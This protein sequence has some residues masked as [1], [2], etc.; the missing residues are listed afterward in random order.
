M[1]TI[2]ILTFL[3]LFL[4]FS[5]KSK[6]DKIIKDVNPEF[7]AYISA[8]TSGLVSTQSSIQILLQ[9]D[10]PLEVNEDQSL[11]D[12]ILDFSPSISGKTYLKNSTTLEFIP[13]EK[14]KQGEIYTGELKLNK[15]VPKVPK[16]LETFEFQFQAKKQNFSAQIE[17][18]QDTEAG[19][20]N[21][22]LV[23]NFNT[24]DVAENIDFE[25][26]LQAELDGKKLNVNWN[27]S[28]NQKNH[29][30]TIEGIKADS[31]PKNLKLN[32]NGKSIEVDKKETT[33]FE[34]PA[35]NDFK[36]TQIRS[37]SFPEQY[38]SVNFSEALQ[39]DLYLNGLVEI[40]GQN[41]DYDYYYSYD[42]EPQSLIQSMVVNGNELKIYTSKKIGGE[43][44]LVIYPGI[45]SAYGNKIEQKSTHKVDLVKLHP[46]VKFIGNGNI[47]PSQ[48]GKINLPFE[49]VGLRAVRVNIT[50]IFENNIHQFFQYNQL[51]SYDNLRPVGQKVFSKVISISDSDNFNIN[52][53]NVYQL[54]LSKFIKPEPGAIYNV[55]FSIEQKFASYPCDAQESNSNLTEIEVV[56][57]DFEAESELY[58]YDYYYPEN[59]NWQDRDNPCTPSY[60]TSE[61]NVRKNILASNLG[62]IYKSGKDKKGYAAVTDINTTKP[63]ENVKLKA[64]DLQN[65]LVGEGS[66]D[67]N[68]FSNFELK[69]KPFLIVAERDSQKGYVRVDNGSSLSLSNFDVEGE[70]S[71]SGLGGFIYGE[72]GVWRPGDKIYLTFL[73]DQSITQITDDQPAVLE[74]KSPDGQLYQRKVNTSPTN[75]FYTFELETP[76]D[77]KTGNWTAQVKV[78]GKTFSKS[79]KIETIKPNRLKI[80]TI[81][82]SE[83]LT[84]SNQ[85]FRIH[86]NWLSGA[87]AQNLKATVDATLF[88]SKTEFKSFPKYT[89]TDPSRSFFLQEMTVFDGNLNAT[90][91][92]QIHTNFNLDTAPPGKLT[93]GLFTKVFETGGDFSSSYVS[94]EFSPYNTYVGIQIPTENEYW[95]MLETNKE[96][97]INVATVDYKGSGISK[98]YVKVYIYRL[99]NSWWYNS[100]QNDLAYYVNRQYEFLK[101]EKVISTTNGKGSFKIKIPNDE[102]GNYFIRV[103]DPESGHAAGKTI[104]FD[105]PDWRSRGDSNAESAAILQFK[106][107]KP[108]YKVGETAQITI[109]SSQEG[110][111]LVSF[112]NGTKVIERKWIETQNGQTKFD[113]KIT[114]EMAP[115]VYVNISLIQ[116]HQ[117]TVNDLPIRMYGV[118]PV[119]VDNPDRQLHPLVKVPQ[120]IRPNS[121]YAVTV[122]EKTGKPMTYTLAVVDEGLLDLTNFKTPDVY[123]YFNQKQALGVNTWDIYNYVLGAYGGRIESV[124]TIGGDQALV[125]SN[126]EKINRFKPIVKFLGPFILDKGK[127]KTHEIHMENYIGS[128]K[129]MVVAANGS[130]FGSADQTIAVKQPLMTL[131]TV[132]RVLNP[133]DEIEVPINVFAMENHVK[134]VNVSIQTD[135]NLTL[136]SPNSQ[137]LS[138]TKMGDQ[139][140][141]FKI[142]VPQKL[143]K[144]RILVSATSGKE[145]HVD[146]IHLEIRSPNPPMTFV[147]SQE[148]KANQNWTQNFEPFGMSGTTETKL[149]LS[150]VPN[151]NLE[152]RLKYLIQYPHGCVE[153]SVSS[154][155]PQLYLSDLMELSDKQKKEIQY[156]IDQLLLKLKSYQVP[157]GG[158]TYWPGH[159]TPD[160]W[161]STY[162]LHFILKA[163]SKGY[164][165]P[166]GLK[167]GLITYQSKTAKQWSGYNEKYYYNDLDQAYRLYTLALAGKADLGLMNRLKEKKTNMATLW[168]L[169]AT[170]QL[171]GQENTAKNLVS[172]LATSVQ[173][174]K[175]EQTTFG[176]SLRDDAMILETLSLLGDRTK[177]MNV[178]KKIAQNLKS[179]Q[180]YSTQTTAY[181]LLAISEFLGKGN[182]NTGIQAEVLI[183][184]KSQKINS[185]KTFV[186]IDLPE[187]K[188]NFVVKNLK[189]NLLFVD[190]SRTGV[191]MEE[192][193][194]SKNQNL[195]MKV[196]YLDMK[197]NP[198]DP[199]KLEQGKDF[200]CVIILTNPGL[201]GN[202]QNLAL[203]QMFPSGWEI[204]NTRI[205]NQNT[206]IK[207]AGVS[208]Q[209]FRDDRV[210][211]YFDLNAGRQISITVLLNATYKGNY[212][213][214]ATYCEAMYDNSISAVQAG[215]RVNVL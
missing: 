2:P 161:G 140:V 46:E 5:C 115:N 25:K 4:L 42:E 159:G 34:I 174:Y 197:N 71:D 62:I 56:S 84:T 150:T 29:R 89:F 162:A 8:Y 196:S 45:Q 205:N 144:T 126:K 119:L 31:N 19:Q 95:E 193:I 157:G 164:K 204:I 139:I 102:Y 12:N 142:K 53:M 180:W 121:K 127:S 36:I 7:A 41:D 96:H 213:M 183:N 83:I 69:K 106:T 112:E 67:S 124:F 178:L 131:T 39:S 181:S 99:K 63:L 145:K 86:A 166:A 182:S 3:T 109:P 143:G 116:P 137:S 170:Y 110:R 73:M 152:K 76:A 165:I 146:T 33:T 85:N 175:F 72:R 87:S 151:L 123:N 17:G 9:S 43:H 206:S 57:D 21:Y 98:D 61:R 202:Y 203:T 172:K 184:G 101:E 37:V 90:G 135:Q 189:S 133:G 130:S 211:S 195:N 198:I 50:K 111:A 107:D 55:E 28:S 192:N 105:W 44:E 65:Q 60:Y 103:V 1:R 104:W 24:A 70:T 129:V 20:G 23:G 215:Y 156:N 149:Y 179:E 79:V 18:L 108:N 158:L 10:Y 15:I 32:W 163:E 91:D 207:N 30:F 132:P 185:T 113:I 47:I 118:I 122:F 169:A 14:L 52:Q 82:P 66:T 100:S 136:S 80:Q 176:S 155:F 68:G 35:F 97:T 167:E 194:A 188:G 59:Y 16:D 27:S 48:D 88:A 54:E 125:N 93:L 38:I 210:L 138:F 160:T 200:K 13:D 117:A 94:Q 49:A 208:Y 92:A 212:Y 75:G 148:I 134:N 64:Y 214:P 22:K 114:P 74:F 51:N 6:S 120:S 199:S 201:M 187:S 153:Q 191:S 190:Y 141:P 78:G 40:I 147:Q 81:F 11:K 173:D 186:E 128:V 154:G 58:D 168:R 26:L 171:A 77:A 177:G 209:D